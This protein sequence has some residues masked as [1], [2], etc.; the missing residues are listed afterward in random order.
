MQRSPERH[1][2]LSDVGA[3]IERSNLGLSSTLWFAGHALGIGRPTTRAPAFARSHQ[4]QGEQ[5]P[6]SA[7]SFVSGA[8]RAELRPQSLCHTIA[9]RYDYDRRET[10]P[11]TI[12]PRHWLPRGA[13]VMPDGYIV[14]GAADHR[15]VRVARSP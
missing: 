2:L 12:A 15:S 7:A 1:V 11:H 3:P 6:P 5:P 9:T 4:R 13:L 14:A 8:P 10:P